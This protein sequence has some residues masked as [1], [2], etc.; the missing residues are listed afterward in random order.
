MLYFTAQVMK[1]L[2]AQNIQNFTTAKKL[3]INCQQ[4]GIFRK[5]WFFDQCIML[6][7]GL[8]SEKQFIKAKTVKFE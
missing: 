3:K 5:F 2:Q 4:F 7:H 1:T 8:H 6:S